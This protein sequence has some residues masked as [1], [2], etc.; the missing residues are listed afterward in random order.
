MEGEER[1]GRMRIEEFY[2]YFKDQ[3]MA[4]FMRRKI[5]QS[6]D[7]KKISTKTLLCRGLDVFE[8]LD[9]FAI[10]STF[11]IHLCFYS[12]ILEKY[13]Y[14]IIYILNNIILIL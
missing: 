13:R 14:S 11:V 5:L 6:I 8:T 9:D 7:L 3:R 4:F 1:N 2:H 10:L 12:R